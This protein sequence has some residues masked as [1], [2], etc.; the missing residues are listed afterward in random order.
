MSGDDEWTDV[1]T[2]LGATDKGAAHDT[3]PVYCSLR[4]W[5]C[6]GHMHE[7]PCVEVPRGTR[8]AADF[9][10]GRVVRK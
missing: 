8:T 6:L 4:P 5:C 2:E 1:V 9:G 3:R 10:P 7:P